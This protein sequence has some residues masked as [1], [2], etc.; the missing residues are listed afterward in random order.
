M[1][2]H[3]TSRDLSVAGRCWLGVEKKA[4]SLDRVDINAWIAL[5]G[6]ILSRDG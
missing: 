6:N 5:E 2:K 3:Q 4:S 1:S